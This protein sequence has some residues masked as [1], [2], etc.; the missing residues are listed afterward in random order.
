MLLLPCT[1]FCEIL[2]IH[3]EPLFLRTSQST[4]GDKL[5]NKHL[6]LCWLHRETTAFWG[7]SQ[8]QDC[9]KLLTQLSR[10][11]FALHPNP[12]WT[13]VEVPNL[14]FTISRECSHFKIKLRPWSSYV[15]L[16]DVKCCRL[17]N[18]ND[19]WGRCSREPSCTVSCLILTYP[20]WIRHLRV[21]ILPSNV[22]N[23]RLREKLLKVKE[24]PHWGVL[25]S[26]PMFSVA[27]ED[28]RNRRLVAINR[29]KLLTERIS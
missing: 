27:F 29:R 26:S 21:Q 25:P 5:R 18:N 10:A 9:R 22:M 24:K 23:L 6:S 3:T 11:S 4:E 17:G 28:L 8:N 19:P 14:L 16:F 13:K 1:L 20:W 7:H 15:S 12:Q 2:S